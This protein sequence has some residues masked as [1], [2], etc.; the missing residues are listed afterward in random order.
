MIMCLSRLENLANSTGDVGPQVKELA[1]K[2]DG[3]S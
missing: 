1:T 3:P 2:S